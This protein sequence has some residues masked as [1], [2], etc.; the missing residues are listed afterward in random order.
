MQGDPPI[1]TAARMLGF[2]GLLPQLLALLVTATGVDPAMG[3]MIA[4]AYAVLIVSF[5]GGIWW[6][7]AMRSGR[8]QPQLAL[9]AVAPTLTAFALVVARMIGLRADWALAAIAAV[10]MLTLMVDRL[11]VDDS[12]APP[13][14]MGLRT[15]L[16]A[17]LAGLTLLTALVAPAEIMISYSS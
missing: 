6:G 8:R 16:T 15:P 10:L 5:L 3:A 1:S 13:G 9:L 2:A 12:V 7:F 4:F 17:G 11:F 14:W